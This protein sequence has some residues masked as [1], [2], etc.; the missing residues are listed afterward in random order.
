MTDSTQYQTVQPWMR[1]L[2]D[3]EDVFAGDVAAHRRVLHPLISIEASVVD[4]SWTGLLHLVTPLEPEDG[5]LGDDTTQ[6]HA[7]YCTENY[8]GFRVKDGRYE[9]LGD[10]RYFLINN[11]NHAEIRPDLADDYAMKDAS[12]EETRRY[13]KET[14]QLRCA[15]NR[16][17]HADWF[18]QVGGEIGD[19]NWASFGLKLGDGEPGPNDDFTPVSPLTEDGRRFRFVCSA[20]GFDYRERCADTI[21]LFFDP[22][23][24]IAVLTFDWT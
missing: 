16:S 24:S 8:I 1:P 22:V 14:G 18:E 20:T 2:P 7:G 3:P 11:A 10:W 6:F 13:Y 4:P 5:L 19:G 21:L 9:F 15:V 12:Y 17:I 23:T